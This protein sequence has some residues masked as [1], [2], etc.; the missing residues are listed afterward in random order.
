MEFNEGMYFKIKST[1]WVYRL[2]GPT[3]IFHKPAWFCFRMPTGNAIEARFI[4][5]E[6]E[7]EA[8]IKNNEIEFLKG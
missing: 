2:E 6:E 8:R 5:F 4:F 3:N 7:I 1:G